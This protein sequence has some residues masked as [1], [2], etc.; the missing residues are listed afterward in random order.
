M[1][2]DKPCS[3]R[4]CFDEAHLAVGLILDLRRQTHCFA[5]SR[6]IIEER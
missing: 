5:R 3:K 4:A 1:R 6:A 2:A